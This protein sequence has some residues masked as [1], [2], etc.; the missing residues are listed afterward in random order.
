MRRYLPVILLALLAAC[1]HVSQRPATLSHAPAATSALRM[2]KQLHIVFDTGY[3]RIVKAGSTWIAVGSLAE[4]TVFKPQGAVFT[5]EG[6]HV[7]EAYLVV[8]NDVL[9]GFYLPAERSFSP[10]KQTLPVTFH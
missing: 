7:H 6:A 1:S 4:G 5:L 3:S 2:V 9:V 10:L 8:S